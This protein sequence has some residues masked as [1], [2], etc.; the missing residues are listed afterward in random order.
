MIWLLFLVGNIISI[1]VNYL[2]ERLQIKKHITGKTIFMV[3]I[4]AMAIF[5]GIM[6]NTTSELVMFQAEEAPNR[7]MKKIKGIEANTNYKIEFEI[8]A[9]SNTTENFT[10][11]IAEQ[12]KFLDDINKKEIKLDNYE[13]IKTIEFITTT[14]TKELGIY[15]ESKTT[16]ENTHLKIKSLKIN[17]KEKVLNYKFLPTELVNKLLNIFESKKGI[18]ERMHLLQQSVIA[19]KDYNFLGIG[20][21]AWRY[22]YTQYI[23][24]NLMATEVHSYIGQITVE[25][26]LIGIIAYLGLIISL[27]IKTI[28]YLLKNKNN[29]KVI[30][31]ACAIGVLFV[32]SILDFDMSFFLILLT[33]YVLIAILQNNIDKEEVNLKNYGVY[34]NYIGIGICI[35]AIIINFNSL[36]GKVYYENKIKDAT[37][38]EERV[39]AQ[40]SNF[41]L[42]PY[43]TKYLSERITGLQRYRKNTKSISEQ[44]N[45][46]LL[47]VIDK[48]IH[49]LYKRE[50]Y[51]FSNEIMQMFG[52]NAI[53]LIKNGET[54]RGNKA[55]QTLLQ[56][57]ERNYEQYKYRTNENFEKMMCLTEITRL[58]KQENLEIAKQFKEVTEKSY[59][60]IKKN[61]AE[62]DK[63]RESEQLMEW[64]MLEIDK[65]MEKINKICMSAMNL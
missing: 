46:E 57:Y 42:N 21:G 65:M 47:I 4:I 62:V 61:W 12:N 53:E 24:Y 44:Q 15:F 25:F 23:D 9:K 11:T 26:G 59:N 49:K 29:I 35:I 50:P 16:D 3:T 14:E 5:G 6:L 39:Q 45:I 58:L 37:T 30:S 7:V 41:M 1:L 17:E 40:R 51:F 36:F 10:I 2:I 13:G 54:E 55:L 18:W 38:R 60:I 19:A 64:N 8:D 34:L 31:I 20:G 32:H 27:G 28:Q 22:I 33:F 63:C 52:K 56:V 43:N 48:Y